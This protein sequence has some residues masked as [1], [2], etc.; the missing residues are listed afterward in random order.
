M[1]KYLS[2][3]ATATLT[4]VSISSSLA[5]FSAPESARAGDSVTV[6]AVVAN[7]SSIPV[8]IWA[9]VR[10]A[11]T[12]EVVGARREALVDPMTMTTFSWTLTMPSKDWNLECHGGHRIDTTYYEAPDSPKTALILLLV[13]TSLTLSLSP[14]TVA[15]GATVTASGSLI[16]SDTNEPL[17]GM[18]IILTLNGTTL[19]TTTTDASGNYSLSFTAPSTVGSYTVTAK[20]E[21]LTVS[22]IF[23]PATATA[24]LSVAGVQVGV[25]SENLLILVPILVGGSMIASEKLKQIVR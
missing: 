25:P 2:S 1:V 23:A 18:T 20:F 5:D 3:Q 15:P 7:G 16:R 21:G 13:P 8:I 12:G 6:R 17:S 10:D 11:D 22:S 14:A 9:E 19:G 24:R 4:V